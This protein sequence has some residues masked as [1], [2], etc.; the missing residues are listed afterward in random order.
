MDLLSFTPLS[1]SAVIV[2]VSVTGSPVFPMKLAASLVT[3]EA[4]MMT[5]RPS[6]MVRTG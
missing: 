4:S 2:R 3:D 6:A 5:F 1:A